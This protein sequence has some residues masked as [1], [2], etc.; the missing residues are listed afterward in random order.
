MGAAYD[1]DKVVMIGS[2][3]SGIA[4]LS[5]DK[6][7]CD[8]LPTGAAPLLQQFAVQIEVYLNRFPNWV[9]YQE[10]GQGV[11]I[12]AQDVQQDAVDFR[13]V[14]T[15]IAESDS[16]DPDVARDI[17]LVTEAALGEAASDQTARGLVEETRELARVASEELV[18]GRVV[19]EQVAEM[20]TVHD[21]EMAKWKWRLGGFRLSFS[22][23]TRPLYGD[24]PSGIQ[25]IWLGCQGFWIGPL[26]QRALNGNMVNVVKRPLVAPAE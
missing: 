6:E 4:D 24:W 3:G 21:A 12:S 19:R 26:V 17:A 20:E 13:E 23:A 25:C 8:C 2:I 5:R 11:R 15:S 10:Q 18:S 9:A 1:P 14:E 16:V 7:F 22:N